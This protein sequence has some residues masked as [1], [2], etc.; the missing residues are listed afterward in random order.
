MLAY[1]YN[2]NFLPYALSI[3]YTVALKRWGGFDVWGWDYHHP[4]PIYL[5][6]KKDGENSVFIT[7]ICN[8]Q[9]CGLYNTFN[10]LDSVRFT[11]EVTFLYS[12][13]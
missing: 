13:V 8:I 2:Y 5:T 1:I 11:V 7:L 6:I 3:V 9:P 12:S 4:P 10:P